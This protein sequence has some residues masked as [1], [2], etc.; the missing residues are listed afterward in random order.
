MSNES[1]SFRIPLEIPSRDYDYE[2]MSRL[3][4]QLRLNFANINTS[5]ETN[6]PIEAME[7]FIS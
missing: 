1:A 2:Y 5:R 3:I 4:N 7:W 6:D